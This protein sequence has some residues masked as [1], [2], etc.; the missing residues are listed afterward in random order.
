MAAFFG[1]V[2]FGASIRSD[3]SD[4]VRTAQVM[5][6]EPALAKAWSSAAM[7]AAV[8]SSSTRIDSAKTRVA[9]MR[10]FA[11]RIFP[12]S[13]TSAVPAGDATKPERAHVYQQLKIGVERVHGTTDAGKGIGILQAADDLDLQQ[14]RQS[15]A[16]L[17]VGERGG[18][19]AGLGALDPVAVQRCQGRR[20][21]NRDL[22][23]EWLLER[24]QETGR[25]ELIGEHASLAAAGHAFEARHDAVDAIGIARKGR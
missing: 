15:V 5:S 23:V 21:G 4:M 11:S 2:A 8:A 22:Q 25:A 14:L 7:A 16:P 20:I 10:P 6:S 3:W 1:T 19:A 24:C 12:A 18:R 17:R 13:S 9:T